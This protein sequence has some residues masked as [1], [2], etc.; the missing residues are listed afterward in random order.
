MVLTQE[1]RNLDQFP[2][3]EIHTAEA[4]GPLRSL[5]NRCGRRLTGQ[6]PFYAGLLRRFGARLIHAHFGYQGCRCLGA[7]RAAG[8]PLLTTFYGADATSY[9]RRP[10]WQRRYRRL[11]DCGALFLAEGTALAR[12]LEEAGAP[13][14]RVRLHHLGVDAATLP[15]CERAPTDRVQVLIC[16]PF[17]QKKGIPDGI[18]ALGRAAAAVPEV[19]VRLVLIG[20]GPEADLIRAALAESGLQERAELRGFQPYSRVVEELARSHLVLQPSRTALDGD[21]EGGAP[22]ILLDAQATGAPVVSTRH[23]DI[24]EYVVDGES[25][26]LADEGDVDGLAQ[27]LRHL[28][29]H[30]DLWPAM[31]RR[32][33]RH[34]EEHYDARRQTHRLEEIYDEVTGAG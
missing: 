23:A 28:L 11:F 17:R 31:G 14:D 19:E 5:A 27:R 1:A 9:A 7:A 21:S 25:G 24:P 8:L 26:L 6:Y 29:T 2:V 22:V 13:P 20:D 12:R 18:R 30:Q 34:V 3:A 32:G 10:E 15:F 33:R 16:A 4:Y